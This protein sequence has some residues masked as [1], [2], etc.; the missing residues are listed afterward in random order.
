MKIKIIFDRNKRA[1][2]TKKGPVVIEVYHDGK[3]K[4]IPTDVS[5][6]TA[7]WD[8]RREKVKNTHDCDILNDRINTVFRNVEDVA[9]RVLE[10]NGNKFDMEIFQRYIDKREE[11]EMNFVDFMSWRI[12]ER[13]DIRETTKKMQRKN[14]TALEEFGKIITFKDLTKANIIDFD[15]FL[16]NKGLKQTTIHTYHKVNKV[17]IN[18]A[19]ARE[20]ITS[21]PYVGFKSPRG[22]SEEGRWLDEEELEKLKNAALPTESLR[23]VRDLF[24]FQCLTGVAYAD[25]MVIDFSKTEVYKGVTYVSAKRQKTS[26]TFTCVLMEEAIEILERYG[27][28]LPNI[29]NAKYNLYLKSVAAYSGIDKPIASHWGRRTCGMVLLNRGVSIEVVAKVLGHATIRVTEQVYAK[30]L[31]KSVAE[32]FANLR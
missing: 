32:T 4:F 30:V 1:T 25:L 21:S 11:M 28:K 16:R 2:E 7:Q 20:L 10:D 19:I 3:R 24:V 13:T 14:L 23:H 18:E 5:V 8:S 27:Y 26:M 12:E 15:H 9:H 17:Y 29:S 22:Q 6:T 31:D